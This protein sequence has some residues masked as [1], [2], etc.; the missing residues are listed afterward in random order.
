MAANTEA[1][2]QKTIG[3]SCFMPTY[4][5]NRAPQPGRARSRIRRRPVP[6]S[7][8]AAQGFKLFGHGCFCAFERLARLLVAPAFRGCARAFAEERRV[9]AGDEGGRV[10]PRAAATEAPDKKRAAK[11]GSS[12]PSR[13]WRTRCDRSRS[14]LSVPAVRSGSR[15]WS[16]N[17]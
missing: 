8:F 7:A 1:T 17:G 15:G 3:H 13:V 2:V 10:R 16:A 14:R 5:S 9:V 12:V 11:G 4:G 6:T